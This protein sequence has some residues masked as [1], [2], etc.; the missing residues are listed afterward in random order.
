MVYTLRQNKHFRH[1]M[2][3]HVTTSGS[4]H[5]YT[6]SEYLPAFSYNE[7]TSTRFALKLVYS[8]SAQRAGLFIY[9]QLAY[10][11]SIQTRTHLKCFLFSG[12]WSSQML[13]TDSTNP[14][15]NIF[16]NQLLDI[17]KAAARLCVLVCNPFARSAGIF[18]EQPRGCR[19]RWA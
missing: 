17:T 1:E 10:R 14:T 8:H 2:L 11:P 19:A 3:Q 7:G 6:F 13:Q 15:H 18:L 4:I 16:S 9:R 5:F 12:K